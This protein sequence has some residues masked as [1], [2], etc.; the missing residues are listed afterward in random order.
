MRHSIMSCFLL[1]ALA[2]TPCLVRADGPDADRVTAATQ[3]LQT[4]NM[5]KMLGDATTSMLDLQIKQNPQLQPFRQVMLDFLVKYMGWNACKEDLAKLYAEEFT[6]EELNQMAAFY[7]TPVG[8]KLASKQSELMAKG[9][10]LGQK[11]VADH[12]D[13]LRQNIEAAAKKNGAGQ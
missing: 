7:K 8:Q 2:V 13:E 3:L 5:E 11:R 6:V 10:E 4:M 9:A 12:S 1:L